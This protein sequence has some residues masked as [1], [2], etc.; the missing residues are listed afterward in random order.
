MAWALAT[1][2]TVESRDEESRYL[3]RAARPNPNPHSSTNPNSNHLASAVNRGDA[4]PKGRDG[5]LLDSE[6]GRDL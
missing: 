5:L 6:L 2:A 1:G 4:L 3:V